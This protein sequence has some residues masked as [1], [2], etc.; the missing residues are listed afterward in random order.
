MHARFI[1]FIGFIFSCFTV[2]LTQAAEKI[3]AQQFADVSHYISANWHYLIRDVTKCNTFG[4]PKMR[5]NN[6]LYFPP[7]FVI[8]PEVKSMESKCQIK[9]S[10]L[11]ANIVHLARSQER[12]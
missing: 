10:Y 8:P 12:L 1:F 9:F 2:S 7:R 3:P 5:G 6:L 11:P 4:D